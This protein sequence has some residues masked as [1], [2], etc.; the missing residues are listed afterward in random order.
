MDEYDMAS[1]IFLDD[2]YIKEFSTKIKHIEKYKNNE[3]A[4]VLKETIFHPQSGGQ[5]CDTGVIESDNTV[6]TVV[7]VHEKDGEIFHVVKMKRGLFHKGDTVKCK[8]NWQR[9]YDV[10]R[11]H[12]GEH[13]LARAIMKN[14]PNADILKVHIGQQKGDLV[15]KSQE[16]ISITQLTEIEILSN[17]IVYAKLPVT[18][19]K[20]NNLAEAKDYYKDRLREHV[21]DPNKPLRI[22]EIGEYDVAAC[23]GTHVKNTGEIGFIKI[24][25]IEGSPKEY[26]IGFVVADLAIKTAIKMANTSLLLARKHTTSVEELP[27]KIENL[28]E[29]AKDLNRKISSISKN[30]VSIMMNQFVTN[31][32]ISI[33]N[34]IIFYGVFNDID[35][36]YI[37]PELKMHAKRNEFGVIGVVR[38]TANIIVALPPELESLGSELIAEANKIIEGGGSKKDNLIIIG[39]R[40]P[41]RVTQCIE[42]IIRM[43]KES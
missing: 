22:I 14:V 41:K 36:K 9:R 24:T 11:A 12:T 35:M 25:G 39:G 28:A 32:K 43:I 19:R 15:V 17:E 29:W 30:F 40:N 33:N 10:M 42:A 5:I 1:M 38:K 21:P 27:R 2:A 7:D 37:I 20:F 3:Y 34:K 18:I 8:L 23:V 16:E 31:N 26:R 4:I 13:I 6:G